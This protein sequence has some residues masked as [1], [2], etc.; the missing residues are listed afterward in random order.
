MDTFF[1]KAINHK[2]NIIKG[3]LCCEDASVLYENTRKKGYYVYHLKNKTTG[4]KCKKQRRLNNNNLSLI[5]MHMHSFLKCGTDFISAIEYASDNI[6]NKKIKELLKN[7]KDDIEGGNSI[8]NAFVKQDGVFPELFLEMIL[9][10]E[11]SG[12]ITESFEQLGLYYEKKDKISKQVIDALSYPIFVVAFSITILIFMVSEIIPMFLTILKQNGGT[13]PLITQ[14]VIAST[15]F[16]IDNFRYFLAAFILLLLILKIF[17]KSIVVNKLSYYFK[18]KNLIIKNIFTKIYDIKTGKNLSMLLSGGIDIMSSVSI[19]EAG[20]K[21]IIIKSKFQDVFNEIREGNS[22]Y[23][24][25]RST[26]LLSPFFLSMI[27]SGEKSGNLISM[28]NKACNI[29]E[30]FLE[31]K[32]SRLVKLIQP[33]L[34]IVISIFVGIIILSFIIP[35]YN[36]MDKI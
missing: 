32:I 36:F 16:L 2:G 27:K 29:S 21:N 3:S 15:R 24:A 8:Y 35:F 14:I 1:F 30:T 19:M 25:F 22:I 12:N 5:C 20:E 31:M 7:I 18:F 13:I 17:N 23:E 4:F 9:I 33:I 28:L 26:H 34:I 11:N 6:R 10:G